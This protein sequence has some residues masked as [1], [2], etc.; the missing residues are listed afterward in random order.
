M[1]SRQWA[2]V[3]QVL[4]DK[5]VIIK[6][7]QLKYQSG[8]S[9]GRT[10]PLDLVRL[11]LHEEVSSKDEPR[12]KIINALQFSFMKQSN[13]AMAESSSADRDE[14]NALHHS[15]LEDEYEGMKYLDFEIRGLKNF[16]HFLDVAP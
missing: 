3:Q 10:R 5:R 6:E 2:A 14:I 16:G 13:L 15:E 11:K 7:Y 12:Q 8:Q 4:E 1:N 9:N